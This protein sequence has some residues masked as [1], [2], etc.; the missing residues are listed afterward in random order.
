M[1]LRPHQ[2]EWVA[3]HL[4]HSLDIHK[5]FYRHT[6]T[7]VERAQIAKLLLLAD[8]GKTEDLKNK[9]LEDVTFQG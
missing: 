4:G 8:S 7:V 5:S 2:M 1:E 9:K 6:S 3:E